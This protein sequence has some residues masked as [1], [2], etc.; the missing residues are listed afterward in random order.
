MST[1][2]TN[3]CR[4]MLL[5]VLGNS[6]L[7]N[8]GAIL[9]SD[10]VEEPSNSEGENGGD[11]GDS[12]N[13]R[14]DGDGTDEDEEDPEVAKRRK[15]LEKLTGNFDKEAHQKEMKRLGLTE[16]TSTDNDINDSDSNSPPPFKKRSKS[17]KPMPKYKA[18]F[19]KGRKPSIVES[20]MDL[21]KQHLKIKMEKAAIK[22]AKIEAE[23]QRQENEY[24]LARQKLELEKYKIEMQAQR[25][26]SSTTFTTPHQDDST[27]LYSSNS[28]IATPTPWTEFHLGDDE[29]GLGPSITNDQDATRL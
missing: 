15:E 20:Q 5:P 12:D 25:F 29:L 24:Q 18:P 22:R 1:C 9:N 13:G 11:S 6:S 16:D 17:S 19:N 7:I 27:S 28:G 8:P 10:G 14:D 2:I 4:K 26:K 23:Q 3:L 21:K